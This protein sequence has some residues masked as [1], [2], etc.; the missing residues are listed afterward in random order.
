MLAIMIP[1][2]ALMV[3]IDI[4]RLRR[5]ALWTR[6]V[7]RLF[8]NMIRRHELAGDWTGATYILLS[9]CLT[10]ALFTKPIAVAALAFIMVGDTLAALVGRRFGRHRFGHKSVEGSLACLAGTVA[11]ALVVP[12][13]PLT[14]GLIGALVAAIAEAIPFGIDDNVTV[15][16]ISGASMSIVTGIL[17]AA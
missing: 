10:V 15:P 1:I 11:V 2:A 7:A 4:A 16:L 8:G 9:V 14:V 3:A 17:A 13:L 5:W 12:G 6:F